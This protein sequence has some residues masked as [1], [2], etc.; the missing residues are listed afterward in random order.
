MLAL[1]TAILVASLLGSLHCVGM[2]GPLALW[3]TGGGQRSGTIATYHLGRLTTYLIA[4]LLA[5]LL[6]SAVNVGGDLAGFQ[7]LAAKVAGGLLVIVGVHRLLSLLPRFRRTISGE[8]PSRVAALL[9]KA[10]PLLAGRGPRGRAYLGGLMTTWLPCGWLYL[11]VLVAGGTGGLIA[12]LV[13]MTAFWIGTLPALTAVWFGAKRVVPRMGT[14]LP[15]VAGVLL[16]ATGLYTATGRA[17][18]DLSKMTSRQF[19]VQ[20]VAPSGEDSL[21][22]TSLVGLADQPLPC[23]V[24]SA[25]DAANIESS[26]R[27]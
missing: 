7:M 23:C 15:I 16:I 19:L 17:A 2:C 11:F 10:K 1:G 26:K 9:Q 8:N 25:A 3:A 12:A 24:G 4:G 14:S 20:P 13:V 5:G 27:P 21:S 6:G 18:A 22:A